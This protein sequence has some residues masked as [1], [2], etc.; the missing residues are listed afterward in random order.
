MSVNW[1]AAFNRLFVVIDRDGETYFSGNRFIQLAQEVSFDIP[2][3][4]TFI[5]QRQRQGKSTTRRNFFWD[6][7]ASFS[8]ADKLAI[9]SLFIETLEPHA[10]E[11]IT[12]L[13]EFLFGSGSAVPTAAIPSKLSS[14]EKL[15]KS[16]SEIDNAINSGQ[17]NRAVTLSYSCLEGL[18]KAYITK[19]T[20]DTSAPNDL[21][22][23]AKIV[24][25]DI[26][27]KVKD[28]EPAP[29]QIINSIPTI[30]NAIANS[31]NGFSESHFDQDAKKWLAIY[32]RDLTNSI[33]RLLLHF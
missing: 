8:E 18:Y 11:E 27:T 25:N 1:I 16:L 15:S 29:E 33:G 5:A 4:Q 20:L 22:A 31:R 7:I 6:I 26:L 28:S 21:L 23:M 14:A 19:N 17:H 12:E 10:K 24:K 30:T 13:K 3:Y 9:F 32:A 2:D